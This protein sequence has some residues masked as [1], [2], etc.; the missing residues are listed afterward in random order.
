MGHLKLFTFWFLGTFIIYILIATSIMFSRIT[1]LEGVK[2]YDF[3]IYVKLIEEIGTDKID[4]LINVSNVLAPNNKNYYPIA[5]ITNERCKENGLE[6]NDICTKFKSINELKFFLNNK[7]TIDYLGEKLYIVDQDRTL[8]HRKLNNDL[9]LVSLTGKY[10]GQDITFFKFITNDWLN[11]FF[12]YES[13]ISGQDGFKK[14]WVKTKESFYIIFSISLMLLFIVIFLQFRNKEKFKLLKEKLNL[15]TKK[16]EKLSEDYNELN[17]Q[18]QLIEEE[19]DCKYN[20]ENEKKLLELNKELEKLKNEM[21]VSSKNEDK[22]FDKLK[23]QSN[24]LSNDLKSEELVKT[25]SEIQTIKQLWSREFKWDNRLNLESNITTEVTN[26]PFTLTI[27]FILFEN[28]FIDKFA[29]KSDYYEIAA[30]NLEKKI[31]LVCKEYNL[32]L[33]VKEKFHEI[34]KARN[35]W[36]HYG[37]KPNSKIINDL[38]S[39]L[40]QYDIKADILI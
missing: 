23:K 2:V 15:E 6:N 30:I 13:G 9:H 39:V 27:A 10:L 25:I 35:K 40:D 28:Q 7:K 19:I 26:I 8:I 31:D 20:D 22:I 11:Y 14:T 24:H 29:R 5:V 38:L 1:T 3:K 33:E 12:K 21:L 16:I 4:T 18:K 37:K 34:R 17:Y 32:S 36:F